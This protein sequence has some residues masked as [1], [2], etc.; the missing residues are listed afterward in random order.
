MRGRVQAQRKEQQ[1]RAVQGAAPG[2]AL[3]RSRSPPSRPCPPL[4]YHPPWPARQRARRRGMP[5]WP[6]MSP[7][8]C[9]PLPPSPAGPGLPGVHPVGRQVQLL[10]PGLCHQ[11]HLRR[12]HAVRRAQ[13]RILVGA[14]PGG[15]C[16]LWRGLWADSSPLPFH[17]TESIKYTSTPPSFPSRPAAPCLQLCGREDGQAGVQ[18]LPARLPARVP[19]AQ[20]LLRRRLNHLQGQVQSEC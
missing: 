3:R 4:P 16:Y 10:R 15:C 19:Q 14:A 12:L 18:R 7:R 1:M 17:S 11:L 20:Q 13:L 5:R 9:P 6:L 2:H 8:G